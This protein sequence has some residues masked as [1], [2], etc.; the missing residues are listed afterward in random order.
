MRLRA[1][2]RQAEHHVEASFVADGVRRAPA[3]GSFPDEAAAR[4]WVETE[5]AAISA[6][7][8]WEEGD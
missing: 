6:P 4:L 7:V 2:L 3:W 8:V 1:W 5:A